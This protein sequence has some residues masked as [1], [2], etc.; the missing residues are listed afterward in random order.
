MANLL[1]TKLKTSLIKAMD[2]ISHL[3]HSQASY[4]RESHCE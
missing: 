2:P 3:R 4:T 1:M